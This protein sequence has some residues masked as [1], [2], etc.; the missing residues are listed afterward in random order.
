MRERSLPSNFEQ[1]LDQ[2]Y[3]QCRQGS[4][5]IADWTEEFYRLGT[6]TNFAE[7]K[8]YKIARFIDGLRDDIQDQMDTE[9]IG[10]LSD[11]IFMATKIEE[12]IDKKRLRTPFHHT[13]WDKSVSSKLAASVSGKLLTPGGASTSMRLKLM[14]SPRPCLRAYRNYHKTRY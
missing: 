8:D 7:S 13:N 6:R 11:A 10:L 5:S 9:P 3:Q 1:L 14:M 2:Q 12:K 4:K